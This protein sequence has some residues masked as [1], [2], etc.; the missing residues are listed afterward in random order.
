MPASARSH[1][2]VLGLQHLS[3]VSPADIKQGYH[4]TL[5]TYHPDKIKQAPPT[6]PGQYAVPKTP[7]CPCIPSIDEIVAAYAVLSDPIKR[8]SYDS[9]LKTQP[10]S[11]SSQGS[12]RLT[13]AGLETF[14]L[15]ELDYEADSLV[16]HTTWWKSCRCGN[17]QGYQVTEEELEEASRGPAHEMQADSSKEVLIGCRGCSLL[18][19]VTFAIKQG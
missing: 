19:R 4:Q 11:G 16:G 7:T 15:E 3:D 17:Q 9:G 18:I 10:K 6:R 8:A 1:Y 13:H 2:D 14:D 5:L 12:K